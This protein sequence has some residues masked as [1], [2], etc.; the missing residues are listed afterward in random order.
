[1]KRAKFGQP[2]I[3]GSVAELVGDNAGRTPMKT[4]DSLSG[5]KFEWVT[6]GGE[7]CL[8]KYLCVDDDWIARA[9]G[10]L[11]VRQVELWRRGVFDRLPGELDPALLGIAAWRNANGRPAAALLMRDVSPF[12]VPPG[13]D[14]VSHATHHQF[15]DHMALLHASMRGEEADDIFPLAHHYIFLGPDMAAAEAE[16][17]TPGVPPEV[18]AGW[19]RFRAAAPRVAGLVETL[20]LD[21]S[22]L[23]EALAE[24]PQTLI[25]GD[26][27]LGNLG[28]R[29][30]RTIILDW[31]RCGRGPAA[32][33]LAWYL[34]VNCD[35]L[36][37]TKDAAID[38]YRRRLEQHGMDTTGWWDRQLGLAL[39]G[40]LLQL[41]WAKT[42]DATEIAW[43]EERALG[44]HS[45][46]G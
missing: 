21:P 16:R 31:D 19:S 39:L 5:S 34:A 30:G 29:Q 28:E 45:L 2:R 6:V 14:L 23:A 8:L 40:G 20:L 25:H 37:E 42:H 33:D 4:S 43:W 24:T 46:L 9:T 1:M 11:G 44:A 10:D 7:R 18:G 15:L 35:R 12:M 36:P 17:G 41:G 3:A 27:K 38:F 32:L 26:W 13:G 22:P